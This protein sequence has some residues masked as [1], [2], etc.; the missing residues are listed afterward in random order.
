[1][2]LGLMGV[3]VYFIYVY[4][5]VYH[6]KQGIKWFRDL[7]SDLKIAEFQERQ[8]FS[9]PFSFFKALNDD[10]FHLGF[11]DSR[12]KTQPSRTS[13]EKRGWCLL[14]A[15]INKMPQLITSWQDW[16]KF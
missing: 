9:G 16:S 7:A 2:I 8:I 3:E 12:L 6:Q 1:M 11:Q 13:I 4:N 15:D 10:I 14:A 5:I